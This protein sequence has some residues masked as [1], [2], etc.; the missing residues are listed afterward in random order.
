[1]LVTLASGH[2]F[3]QQIA[4]G[5][6]F[7]CVGHVLMLWPWTIAAFISVLSPVFL[8]EDLSKGINPFVICGS[9]IVIRS[10]VV[11]FQT[12]LSAICNVLIK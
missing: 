4:A 5:Q 8:P 11:F 9:D 3:A 12:L 6:C 10:S 2:P 1:M 7:H